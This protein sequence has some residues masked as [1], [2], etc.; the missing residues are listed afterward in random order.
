VKPL[1]GDEEYDDEDVE[2][3]YDLISEKAEALYNIKKLLKTERELLNDQIQK[4][5][6]L[7][8]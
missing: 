5:E 1:E 4:I 8:R 2:Y 6:L 3:D 7:K